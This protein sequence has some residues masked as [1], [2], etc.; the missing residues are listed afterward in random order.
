MHLQW[1]ALLAIFEKYA[2]FQRLLACVAVPMDPT[3]AE[4]SDDMHAKRL[5]LHM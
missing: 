4:H 1:S 3:M 5:S 2:D